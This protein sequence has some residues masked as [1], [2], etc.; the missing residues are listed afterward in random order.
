MHRVERDSAGLDGFSHYAAPT[1]PLA[2]SLGAQFLQP[3]NVFIREELVP[4]FLSE[5]VDSFMHG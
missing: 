5:F 2:S 4:I 3:A 1:W